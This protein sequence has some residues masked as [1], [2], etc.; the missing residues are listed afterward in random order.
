MR[1]DSFNSF[2]SY[3]GYMEKPSL[4]LSFIIFLL[5]LFESTRRECRYRARRIV[6]IYEL[7]GEQVH[8]GE[9]S[10]DCA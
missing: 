6:R 2:N 10:Q 8:D 9:V 3:S 7:K 4:F 5:R 1:V